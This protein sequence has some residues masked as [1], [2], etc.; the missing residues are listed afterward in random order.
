MSIGGKGKSGMGG[1]HLLLGEGAVQQ[2]GDDGQVATLIVGRQD[3]RVLVG[4]HCCGR[5]KVSVSKKG[6]D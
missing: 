5:R 1:S 6:G 4:C 2:P 3:D